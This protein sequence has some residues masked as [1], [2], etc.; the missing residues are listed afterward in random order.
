MGNLIYCENCDT[1]HQMW[2]KRA[3]SPLNLYS[4]YNC[5]LNQGNSLNEE[6]LWYTL[7]PWQDWDLG[8]PREN[9]IIPVKIITSWFQPIYYYGN[10]FHHSLP[11]YNMIPWR[12]WDFSI[13]FEYP[14]N[15]FDLIVSWF[16]YCKYRN[17]ILTYNAMTMALCTP[18]LH[19]IGRFR[20]LEMIAPLFLLMTLTYG[21]LFYPTPT[22]NTMFSCSCGPNSPLEYRICPV[23]WDT[24]GFLLPLS[25]YGNPINQFSVQDSTQCNELFRL[26]QEWTRLLWHSNQRSWRSQKTLPCFAPPQSHNNPPINASFPAIRDLQSHSVNNEEVNIDD[27]TMV[28]TD[29]FA[30]QTPSDEMSLRNLDELSYQ[31]ISQN[32][33]STLPTGEFFNECLANN[34][35]VLE[36]PLQSM[37]LSKNL[38]RAEKLSKQ[39]KMEI[40]CPHSLKLQKPNTTFATTTEDSYSESPSKEVSLNNMADTLNKNSNI[41]NPNAPINKSSQNPHTVT[42]TQCCPIPNQTEQLQQMFPWCQGPPLPGFMQNSMFQRNSWTQGPLNPMPVQNLPQLNLQPHYN[43]SQ[44]LLCCW[45]EW[46][47]LMHQYLLWKHWFEHHGLQRQTHQHLFNQCP[48]WPL[49]AQ[50]MTFSHVPSLSGRLVPPS[51]SQGPLVN[52]STSPYQMS[53]QNNGF[54]N[55]RL[56]HGETPFV[57]QEPSINHGVP[58]VANLPFTSPFA[59]NQSGTS[60]T[61]LPSLRM[62]QPPLPYQS[63]SLLNNEFPHCPPPHQNEPFTQRPQ[64]S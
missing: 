28:N 6:N 27:V 40:K 46:I 20:S 33:I 1:I 49:V 10:T 57:H 39:N 51:L 16:L 5:L 38:T 11:V 37:P 15:L 47:L 53:L 17:Q 48:Q 23:H 36:N 9:G 31:N 21:N 54:L 45:T 62:P 44:S 64:L 22:L 34:T 26:V 42:A 32:S 35:T 60:H 56:P 14:I 2:I 18:L 52:P 4:T 55:Q 13:P 43:P 50:G 3:E 58:F 30:N 63:P 59:Q 24:S 19:Q 25:I 41:E 7:I 61:F 8:T 12:A 29:Q